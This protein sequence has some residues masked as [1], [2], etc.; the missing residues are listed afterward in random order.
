MEAAAKTVIST[1]NW[2]KYPA[3]LKRVNFKEEQNHRCRGAN[4]N[5]RCESKSLPPILRL[6]DNTP[7]SGA[8]G[9]SVRHTAGQQQGFGFGGAD[10]TVR[11]KAPPL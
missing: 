4:H 6:G 11:G 1:S 5:T 7:A 10:R 3:A 8:D 9:S 2:T